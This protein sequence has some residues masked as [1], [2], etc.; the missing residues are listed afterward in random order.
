M[1]WPKGKKR[2]PKVQ[3]APAAESPIPA[4]APEEP[5]TFRELP[6]TWDYRRIGAGV[7]VYASP[8]A[9]EQFMTKIGVKSPRSVRIRLK[10]GQLIEVDNILDLSPQALRAAWI[11]FPM[12]TEWITRKKS[13]VILD[14]AGAES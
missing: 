4:P 7:T 12:V 11:T 6:G 3:A 2:G 9:Q 10:D 8:D 5:R 13:H 1:A 14:F